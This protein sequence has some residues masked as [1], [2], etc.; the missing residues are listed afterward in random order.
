MSDAIARWMWTVNISGLVMGA[1]M[2]INK[3]LKIRWRDGVIGPVDNR[4]STLISDRHTRRYMGATF[5]ARYKTDS[6][7]FVISAGWWL[8]DIIGW[9]LSYRIGKGHA[10]CRPY[11]INNGAEFRA[12][13]CH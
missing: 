1:F 7:P 3:S 4:L 8:D 5:F 13:R 9:G 11:G 10:Q 6:L 2:A 12:L